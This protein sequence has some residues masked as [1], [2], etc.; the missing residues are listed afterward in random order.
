MVSKSERGS[1]SGEREGRLEWRE[2][3]SGEGEGEV[4]VGK[5]SGE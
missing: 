2:S 3:E 1:E 4:R 5:D